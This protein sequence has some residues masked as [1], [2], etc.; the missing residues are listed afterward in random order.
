MQGNYKNLP[1]SIGNK[2]FSLQAQRMTT[3][4]KTWTVSKLSKPTLFFLEQNW[5]GTTF[6]MNVLKYD[7]T[8]LV[9]SRA[10]ELVHKSSDSNSSIFKTSDSDSSIFKTPTPSKSSIGINNGK[11][12]RH[13]ITTT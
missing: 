5:L 3:K 13:F 7:H 1:A 11:P 6:I 12:I 2:V 10:V 8:T 9:K 4:L